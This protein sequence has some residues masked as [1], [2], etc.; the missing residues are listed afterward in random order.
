M[1]LRQDLTLPADWF[2]GDDMILDGTIFTSDAQVTVANITGAA[3][4][5]MVKAKRTDPDSR[6]LI[7]KTTSDD[8]TLTSPTN[9]LLAITVDAADIAGLVA[10][11]V[12]YHELK[13]TNPGSKKV[14]WFG[15]LVLNQSVHAT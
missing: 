10:E 7:V 11:R 5:W 4:S 8:I 13:R 9:G 14:A 3:F 2:T 1:A 12:Y 15:T 6:A